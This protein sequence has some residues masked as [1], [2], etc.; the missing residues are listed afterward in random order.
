MELSIKRSFSHAKHR[1]GEAVTLALKAL[2]S[3]LWQRM[4]SPQSAHPV[5]HNTYLRLYQ[6]SQPDLSQR[7]DITLF[8]EAQDANPVT[9]DILLNN[10]AKIVMVG[11]AHQQIYR[12]RGGLWTR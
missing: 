1:N 2:R 7:F 10:N 3:A 11:D 12:F 6:L 9:H 8:D 4:T 5:T